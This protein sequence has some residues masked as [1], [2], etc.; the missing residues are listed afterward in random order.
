MN[1]GSVATS[2]I[3]SYEQSLSTTGNGWKAPQ[4]RLLRPESFETGTASVLQ[5]GTKYGSIGGFKVNLAN[6][7]ILPTLNDIVNMSAGSVNIGEVLGI[8]QSMNALRTAFNGSQGISGLS[9]DIPTSVANGIVIST[10]G[11]AA[12]LS[13]LGKSSLRVTNISGTTAG[14]AETIKAV[15]DL[16]QSVASG[17]TKTTASSGSTQATKSFQTPYPMNRNVGTVFIEID[18]KPLDD[19]YL[20]MLQKATVHLTHEHRMSTVSLIFNNDLLR[21]TNDPIWDEYKPIR[22]HF[23][24]KTTSFQQVGGTFYSLGPKLCFGQGPGNVGSIELVG[25]SEEFMMGIKQER[26]VWRNL[27]D[28]QIV[29]QI[30]KKYNFLAAVQE[31]EP[32]WDQVSQVNQSDWDFIEERAE[33]YGYQVYIEDSILHWHKPLF[34]DSGIKLL[35]FKGDDSQLSGF[36]VWGEPLQNGNI[37]E[38]SQIDPITGNTYSVSSNNQDDMISQR[39]IGNF[40]NNAKSYGTSSSIRRWSDISTFGNLENTKYVY[41]SGRDPRI[42]QT[43][44]Q[45]YC[46]NSRWLMR[47]MAKSIGIEFLRARDSIELSGVGRASGLYYMTDVYHRYDNGAYTNEVL[48]TRTWR[49]GPGQ[50]NVEKIPLQLV[51]ASE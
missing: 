29:Q 51:E 10:S 36:T 34:R 4:D 14:V 18:G 6:K 45:G 43:E 7:L 38:G 40:K 30:A 46:E 3:K 31:T 48:L 17:G 28:A 16:Q 27:T 49:G 19:T 32:V 5:S 33:Q 9:K 15:T 20:P 37:I 12:S 39:G 47:G 11:E 8:V 35:Y 26:T 21:F 22:I 25:V 2:A 44:A 23:G 41:H 1:W 50:S 13:K 42:L 24:Y